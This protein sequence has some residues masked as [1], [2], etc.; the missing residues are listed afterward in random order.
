MAASGLSGLPY[1]GHFGAMRPAALATLPLP[2]GPMP[3]RYGSRPLKAWRYVAFI[4]AEAI[5]CAARARMGP[6]RDGFWAVWDREHGQLH[7]G[8]ALRAGRLQLR[9]GAVSLRARNLRVELS[10]RE[11]AGIETVC[12]SGDAY[13][14]TRKQALLPATAL[15]LQDRHFREL[16]GHVLVDDTAAY[17]SRHTSWLWS[18]GAGRAGDGT[19]VAWNLVS[20][21]ND[22]PL[23]SERTVWVGNLD[24]E[25]GPCVFAPD[26]SRVDE[27]VFHEEAVLER[28]T[29][30]GLLRSD[31]RH[32][33]G[34]FS[35]RLPGGI[36]LSE[37]LGV[38]ERHD[39]WW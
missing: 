5:V 24:H 25:P 23:H 17:Y 10:F 28:R 14:W 35:G 19:P 31:Y 8:Q 7:R 36:A 38:M 30:L 29:N 3:A 13:A 9:P 15:L 11:G 32:P 20:G 39:A 21:I 1:R 12:A 34:R 18:A 22:P 33:I 6:L 2:P 27:L 16:S 4:S 37:G 26:L